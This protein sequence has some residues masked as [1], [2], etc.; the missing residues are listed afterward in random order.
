MSYRV[1]TRVKGDSWISSKAIYD[2]DNATE[3][4]FS[5]RDNDEYDVMLV[6][7]LRFSSSKEVMII[8]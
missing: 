5:H 6:Q 8:E 3:L 1:L 4:F 7:E 2:R